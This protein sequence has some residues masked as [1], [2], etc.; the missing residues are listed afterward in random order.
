MQISGLRLHVVEPMYSM[1]MCSAFENLAA[2]AW[3]FQDVEFSCG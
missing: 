2:G 1:M 3:L